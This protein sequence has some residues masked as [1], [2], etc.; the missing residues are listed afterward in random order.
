MAHPIDLKL[1]AFNSPLEPGEN[2]EVYFYCNKKPISGLTPQVLLH[3]FS[4][5]YVRFQEESDAGASLQSFSVH[6]SD[7]N[8]DTT[9]MRGTLGA[10][11]TAL[12]WLVL[13]GAENHKVKIYGKTFVVKDLPKEWPKWDRQPSRPNR[14]LLEKFRPYFSDKGWL[15]GNWEPIVLTNA[16]RPKSKHNRRLDLLRE[17]VD[18]ELSRRVRDMQ[19]EHIPL[20]IIEAFEDQTEQLYRRALA[21]D[22]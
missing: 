19:L 8:P 2:L 22:I 9:H 18:A 17:Q 21:R 12:N 16:D 3:A 1:K 6:V 7:K 14:D 13:N 4:T 11:L 5:A 15:Y 10:M 20:D